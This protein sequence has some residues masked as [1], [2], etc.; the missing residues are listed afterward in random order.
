MTHFESVKRG[1][2][3]AGGL[4]LAGDLAWASGPDPGLPVRPPGK[5]FPRLHD[6]RLTSHARRALLEDCQLAPLNLGVKVK[7]GVA[8]LWGPVPSEK[9]AEEALERVK[10]V[11]GIAG[12]R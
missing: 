12:V 9:V 6:V 5:F 11:E 7:D 3:F 10:G 1:L 4:L 8:T 2:L